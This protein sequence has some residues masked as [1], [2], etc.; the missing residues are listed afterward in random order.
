M[1]VL[2]GEW[3]KSFISS[4]NIINVWHGLNDAR[5]SLAFAFGHPLPEALK[6]LPLN[7]QEVELEDAIVRSSPRNGK[8]RENDLVANYRGL[9]D[10]GREYTEWIA[11]YEFASL[12]EGISESPA[13]FQQELMSVA[14]LIIRSC[15]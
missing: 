11:V 12:P 15:I 2:P 3:V 6:L 7:E 10:Y 4:S 1:Y 14:T 9:S 8:N 13:I 5:M